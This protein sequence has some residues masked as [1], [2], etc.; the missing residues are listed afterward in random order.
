MRT[1]E[2]RRLGMNIVG[3]VV[4]W[5]STSDFLAVGLSLTYA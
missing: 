2:A 4:Q 5:T 3:G 1:A